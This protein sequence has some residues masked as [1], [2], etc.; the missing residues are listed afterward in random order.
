MQQGGVQQFGVQQGGVL[1]VIIYLVKLTT[2]GAAGTGKATTYFN[3]QRIAFKC[4]YY[5]R[6]LQVVKG[7]CVSIFNLY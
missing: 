1:Q 2:Y 4:V 6:F 7:L 3:M 5:V